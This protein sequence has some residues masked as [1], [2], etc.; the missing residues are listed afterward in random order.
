MKPSP[1]ML[2]AYHELEAK[3]PKMRSFQ[4]SA[5]IRELGRSLGDEQEMRDALALVTDAASRKA[6][7]QG[8]L[9]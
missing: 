6:I 5:K 9:L 1:P 7:A 8:L 2:R 3:Y 4:G